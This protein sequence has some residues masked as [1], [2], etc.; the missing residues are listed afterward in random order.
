M[1]KVSNF[2]PHICNL[3]FSQI[4]GEQVVICLKYNNQNQKAKYIQKSSKI[5]NIK[6]L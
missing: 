2:I 4:T 1:D 6:K 3:N 5:E